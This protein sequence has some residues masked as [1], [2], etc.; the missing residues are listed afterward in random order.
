MIV[1]LHLATSSTLAWIFIVTVIQLN[2]TVDD[3]VIF[4]ICL[5]EWWLLRCF[6]DCK[7]REKKNWVF[8]FWFKNG[9]N[10]SVKWHDSCYSYITCKSDKYNRLYII[11]RV[12]RAKRIILYVFFSWNR[13][14][15]CTGIHHKVCNF[16]LRRLQNTRLNQLYQLKIKYL[17]EDWIFRIGS[18]FCLFSNSKR[19]PINLYGIYALETK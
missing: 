18:E 17:V 15:I 11:F 4:I 19:K 5:S 8:H 12:K 2:L 1:I 9:K 7:E 3:S 14:C 6:D 10:R 13:E 16:Y